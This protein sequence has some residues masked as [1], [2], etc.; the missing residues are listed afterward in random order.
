[1][2][3]TLDENDRLF[4]FGYGL[5]ET[6]KVT[7]LGIEL[8][9]FHW[10]RMNQ[11]SQLLGLN[12]PTYQEWLNQINSFLGQQNCGYPFALRVTLSGGSP[13]QAIQPQL[14][15]NTRQIPY[16]SDD[17][18][19][20]FRVI[21]LST[22]R[23]ENSILT[24]IKSTNYLENILAREE[25]FKSQSQEGLWTNTQG[26]ITEGTI[27]NIFFLR[28]EV[29]YT[30]SLDCGCLA[31]TR[32][33]VVLQLASDLGIS[34]QEGKYRPSLLKEADQIFLTNAL[35]GIMPVSQ[36]DSQP[37]NIQSDM[38]KFLMDEYAKYLKKSSENQ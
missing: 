6:L 28:K 11:G 36:I 22:S 16:T 33:N 35:M 2:T 27:S 17:Y 5:F 13:A 19:R 20:G 23:S 3:I 38:L 1:M 8:P 10:Q 9:H 37:K 18:E 14:F 4:L 12:I 30:P 34:V 31:G 21:F 32:R 26:Y 29:L 15:F 24:K 25:T 7:S